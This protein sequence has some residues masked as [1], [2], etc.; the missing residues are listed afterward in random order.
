[1]LFARNRTLQ[2][3]FF[4]DVNASKRGA[5]DNGLSSLFCVPHQYERWLLFPTVCKT[6]RD[7]FPFWIAFGPQKILI[8]FVYKEINYYMLHLLSWLD[9]SEHLKQAG[10]LP[11]TQPSGPQHFPVVGRAFFRDVINH[12][13]M[14]LTLFFIK[15]L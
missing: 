6:K 11:L 2:R 4:W 8:L 3:P 15:S 13:K 9:C 1:M 7:S 14:K 10:K 5:K 12:L